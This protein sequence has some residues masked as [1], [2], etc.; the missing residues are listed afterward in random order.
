MNN[1]IQNIMK[2]EIFDKTFKINFE[3]RMKKNQN[4]DKIYNEAIETTNKE[5]ENEIKNE[6]KIKKEIEKEREEVSSKFADFLNGRQE[7]FDEFKDSTLENNK[8]ARNIGNIREEYLIYLYTEISKMFF[9]KIDNLLKTI[10]KYFNKKI[11]NKDSMV[12]KNFLLENFFQ[13]IIGDDLS[14]EIFDLL[15]EHRK[16]LY[17]KINFTNQDKNGALF[18]I[19]IKTIS[20]DIY[21]V[22]F[23][24]Y[25]YCKKYVENL[26]KTDYSLNNNLYSFIEQKIKY[27]DNNININSPF[28]YLSN[29]D[30]N[31]FRDIEPTIF[32]ESIGKNKNEKKATN[33]ED[34]EEYIKYDNEIFIKPQKNSNIIYF[35]G[36]KFK[37]INDI[38]FEENENNETIKNISQKIKDFRKNKNKEQSKKLNNFLKYTKNRK[39]KLSDE[40]KKFL[41]L[42]EN[43]EPPE[44]IKEFLKIDEE[45]KKHLEDLKNLKDSR[46]LINYFNVY[47]YHHLNRDIINKIN[48]MDIPLQHEILMHIMLRLYKY[49]NKKT[50]YFLKQQFTKEKRNYDYEKLKNL[51]ILGI[52]DLYLIPIPEDIKEYFEKLNFKDFILNNIKYAIKYCEKIHDK[53]AKLLKDKLGEDE[54]DK[55]IISELEYNSINGDWLDTQIKLDSVLSNPNMYFFMD[56]PLQ[57]LRL[58]SQ[59]PSYSKDEDLKNMLVYDQEKMKNNIKKQFEKQLKEEQLKLNE[60]QHKLDEEQLKLNEE[61]LKLDEKQSNEKQFKLNEKQLVLTKEQFKLKDE[62]FKEK[63][64]KEKIEEAEKKVEINKLTILRDFLVGMWQIYEEAVP[65]MKNFNFLYKYYLYGP[66]NYFKDMF[67][68]YYDYAADGIK[69]APNIHSYKR[70]IQGFFPYNILNLNFLYNY[71][72]KKIFKNSKKEEFNDFIT[73]F[74][75]IEKNIAKAE[76][77][78]IEYQNIINNKYQQRVIASEG[79]KAKEG[80][81]YIPK[82]ENDTKFTDIDRKT[83]TLQKSMGKI[84]L[85]NLELSYDGRFSKKNKNKELSEYLLSK[86]LDFANK[87]YLYRY[88]EENKIIIMTMID[89]I[90]EHINALK[91]YKG[92]LSDYKKDKLSYFYKDPQKY[93]KD[94]N[95]FSNH[96]INQYNNEYFKKPNAQKLD[97]LWDVVLYSKIL[98]EP[99]SLS[100]NVMDNLDKESYSNIES[101]INLCNMLSLYDKDEKIIE[102]Y[103][104]IY[105]KYKPNEN[106]N[107][108][109]KKYQNYKAIKNLKHMPKMP[110][111]FKKNDSTGKKLNTAEKFD[112]YNTYSRMKHILSLKHI[113]Y[114][115]YKIF[116]LKKIDPHFENFKQNGIF[117]DLLIEYEKETEN[118]HPEDYENFYDLKGSSNKEKKD[119]SNK[120]KKL[121]EFID[122]NSTK[123]DSEDSEDDEIKY[124]KA[125]ITNKY[126][127]L[128]NKLENGLRKFQIYTK[129]NRNKTKIENNFKG[130]KFFRNLHLDLNNDENINIVRDSNGGKLYSEVYNLYNNDEKDIDYQ[131]P[132][133]THDRDEKKKIYNLF[134]KANSYSKNKKDLT[135]CSNQINNL[136]LVTKK[137]ALN[138]NLPL[139]DKIFNILL[140]YVN[141]LKTLGTNIDK[142]TKNLKKSYV[143]N[144]LKKFNMKKIIKNKLMNGIFEKTILDFEKTFNS[145]SKVMY[146]REYDLYKYFHDKNYKKIPFKEYEKYINYEDFEEY[147]DNLNIISNEKDKKI[148]ILY[149]LITE[150]I[151]NL[152]T[153]FILYIFS[154]IDKKEAYEQIIEELSFIL[155]IK[156][157]KTMTYEE[158]KKNY[159]II[160]ENENSEIIKNINAMNENENKD[161]KYITLFIDDSDDEDLDIINKKKDEYKNQKEIL[162]NLFKLNKDKINKDKK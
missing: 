53:Y 59:N 132:A 37:L 20:R 101:Y 10:V 86:Q 56:I 148:K 71:L 93:L 29:E 126:G 41:K 46:R 157:N 31:A 40:L 23:E 75:E 124:I 87:I 81:R 49:F 103:I 159:D 36:K 11:L 85:T 67:Q 161:D 12:N 97:F 128:I 5:I 26:Y 110:F 119:L 78:N 42:D 145:I 147:L 106:E 117:S 94:E 54:L 50:D 118:D 6:K 120:E 44:E 98:I 22:L 57:I 150:E 114:I 102:D 66:K 74:E 89:Q 144:N 113:L 19:F 79:K 136:Y 25:Q 14:K 84:F 133:Y 131:N 152:K 139:N 112:K 45:I 138:R 141:V 33:I 91:D 100:K 137:E 111:P 7:T 70:F 60:E 28:L 38:Y 62:Q 47:L 21:K 156:Y 2:N 142:L 55:I 18:L 65:N 58:I 1:D 13:K 153:K 108:K 80:I 64:L 63:R 90:T 69:S 160:D 77:I 27:N 48:Y 155:N 15:K 146:G 116:P 68:N 39:V 88:I 35:N 105:N 127:A 82:T 162:K 125:Y 3:A 143:E 17:E 96:I 122:E 83:N 24:F 151:E 149:N 72:F 95:R 61:K 135:N 107:E 30:I 73:T 154:Q 123:Y 34:D 130:C 76:E 115:L 4:L 92:S 129:I 109:D 134:S 32:L 51:N 121:K 140:E 9:V 52:K 99:M 104:E 8:V 16:T 158:Y 43:I